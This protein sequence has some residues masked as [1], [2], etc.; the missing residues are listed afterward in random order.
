MEIKCVRI[1]ER[2]IHGQVQTAWCG[3][4]GVNRIVIV[5]RGVVKDTMAKSALKV[6]CPTQCK[7]SI[8]T[9]E[10]IVENL[11]INRYEGEKVL[12][13]LKNPTTLCEMI[14]LGFKP[15]EIIVGN[16]GGKANSK[17][18]VKAVSVT[19]EDV[20]GFKSLLQSGVKVYAQMVPAADKV[21]M[22][23]IIEGC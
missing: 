7:L 22:A 9:P 20:A 13:L 10:R 19:E 12:I 21:D 15:E 18:I 6:A 5:D 17:M 16:M 11:K 23:K 14:E 3:H 8:I 1:D 2:L 4:L